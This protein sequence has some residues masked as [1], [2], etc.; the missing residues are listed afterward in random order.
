MFKL[1]Q[2]KLRSVFGLE[3]VELSNK[4]AVK[5]GNK[6]AAGGKTSGSKAYILRS[7][8]AREV[9]GAAPPTFNARGETKLMGVAMSILVLIFNNHSISH[10]AL[11]SHLKDL[12]I[13]DNRELKE[14]LAT[15]V[16]QGYLHRV[17]DDVGGDP[18]SNHARAGPSELEDFTKQPYQYSWGPRARV[19]VTLEGISTFM[20]EV[21]GEEAPANL[22]AQLQRFEDER[23]GSH[24]QEEASTTQ[25]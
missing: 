24:H 3:L 16:K 23:L 2:E 12:G 5:A 9:R 11:L 1:A 10:A 7:I 8:L 25:T 17:R 22:D 20:R 19:E 15:I 21:F 6:L 18:T 14:L 13:T 4:E